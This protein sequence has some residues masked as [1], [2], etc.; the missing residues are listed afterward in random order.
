MSELIGGEHVAGGGPGRWRGT[1]QQQ[2]IQL[3]KIV[4]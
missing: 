3:K 2:T 4:L 1:Q